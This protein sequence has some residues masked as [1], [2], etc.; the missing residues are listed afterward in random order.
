MTYFLGESRHLIRWVPTSDDAVNDL[1]APTLPTTQ[2]N[3]FIVAFFQGC[4]ASTTIGTIYVDTAIT[5]HPTAAN[6]GVFPV[7]I[8]GSYNGT[9]L[10]LHQ[11]RKNGL[12]PQYM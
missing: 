10:L 6:I 1:F 12:K 7:S 8:R 3:G 2:S 9:H 4:A 11:L 5:V